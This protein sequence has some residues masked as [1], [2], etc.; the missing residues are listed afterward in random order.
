MSVIKYRSN[1]D[2]SLSKILRDSPLAQNKN[3]TPS[4]TMHTSLFGHCTAQCGFV[5]Q[6]L[7]LIRASGCQ[8]AQLGGEETT[9]IPKSPQLGGMRWELWFSGYFPIK[10][11]RGMQRGF[12]QKNLKNDHVTSKELCEIRGLSAGLVWRPFP[13]HV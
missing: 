5:C 10:G 12:C 4:E 11:Q 6:P 8:K 3:N 7:Q 13:A 1:H 2:I 9:L